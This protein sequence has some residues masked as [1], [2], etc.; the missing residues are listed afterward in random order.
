MLSD[1]TVYTKYARYVPELQR[2]ETWNEI[3]TRNKAM[4]QDK[5]PHLHEDI[6][7]AYQHVYAKRLLPSMRSLQFGGPAVAA[8]NVR[9]FNC[10]FVPIHDGDV[11]GELMFLLMSGTGVGFSVQRHHIA[12]LPRLLQPS[13]QGMRLYQI[14]DSLEGWAQATHELMRTY[15][16]AD[17][18]PQPRVVFDYSLIRPR[19]SPLITAGGRAPGPEPLQEA[20][21]AVE[22]LL[23]SVASDRLS[24]LQAHDIIC[25]LATAVAS[26][27]VRRSALISLFSVDDEAMIQCKAGEWFLDNNQR[28]MANN[29]AVLDRSAITEAQ[30]RELWAM[31]EASGSGEP[32]VYFSNDRDWGTNP[33]CEVALEPYQFCN[34]TEINASVARS[35]QD[36]NELSRAAALL[37][38]LQASYTDFHFLRPQ[39]R[40]V[41]EAAALLGV[42]MTGT[43]YVGCAA[44]FE[45]SHAFSLLCLQALPAALS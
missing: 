41:T 16:P 13:P 31:V 26:G 37:G 36:L 34:L 10:S 1:L 35:Q 43:G 9:M 44:P 20:L 42:S 27:G 21:E 45:S 2:R 14:P 8:N 5:F 19:G 6:E 18:N 4:H 24:A 17:G 29:S 30:F 40:Q 33:C 7:Q 22:R 38:T 23:Q 3:V 15:L 11:F 32:G 25:H 39:W 12:Q 28:A